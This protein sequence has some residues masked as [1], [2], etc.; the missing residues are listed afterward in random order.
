MA[1]DVLNN[2]KKTF[3]HTT[4]VR[5]LLLKAG[6]ER[7][8][9]ASKK[10]LKCG[11]CKKFLGQSTR[12][13]PLFYCTICGWVHFQCSGL[14]N[15]SEYDKNTFTCTKCKSERIVSSALTENADYRKAQKFYTRI[16]FP[17]SYGSVDRLAKE[18]GI[19]RST[20]EN[21]LA[22]NSTFTKFKQARQRFLRFKV[23]S[24]RINEIWSIDLADMQSI[25][26]ENK[27]VR[28][29]LVAV[30]TLSRYL[31]VEPMKDKNAS[32]TK[33]A[34]QRMLK[35]GKK[36]ISPE[37]V[38]VDDGKE[39]LGAFKNFCEANKI[40]VYQTHNEKKS[41]FAER[42]IRSLKSLIYKYMNESHTTKYVDQLPNF[43]KVINGR[44]NRVTGLAPKNV[45]N[46][47]TS[48]LVSLNLNGRLQKPKFKTGDT[49]RIRRKIE[50][51][52]RG[53]KIQFSHEVFR[54]TEVLTLDPPTY[55][56]VS[57][58]SNEE[59]SGRFYES[60]LVKFL[61]E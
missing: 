52:H 46:K 18:T 60:E 10:K 7:H 5:F 27:N 54:V 43:V 14:A 61:E 45:L 55:R 12:L 20:V 49:V 19:R 33:K 25:A 42:N 37:R 48:Y 47:H 13:R 50:T 30:D 21:Y 58:D 23:Q 32:T 36:K 28:Y 38:W 31:R 8:P 44:V 22:T 26:S 34:F 59:I 1:F 29:L 51:F 39:F 15:A 16:G 53:Y 4:I 35:L 41:A 3:A 2:F 6:I 40:I 17:S 24:Y 56:I 9:G 57:N 11:S